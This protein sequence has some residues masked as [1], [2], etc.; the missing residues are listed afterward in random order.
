MPLAAKAT[1]I[2]ALT[3]FCAGAAYIMLTRGPALLIDLS[4][5]ATRF[6]CL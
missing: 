1:I 2:A 5:A 6:L 4:A 3:L